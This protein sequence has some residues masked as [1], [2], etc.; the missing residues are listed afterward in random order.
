MEP[1]RPTASASVTTD[2]LIWR[3]EAP[4]A[5]SRASSRLRWA[6]RIEKVLMM[7]KTP[8]TSE[9]PANTS[10]NVCRKPRISSRVSWFFLTYS[11]PVRASTPAGS[12]FWAAS[13]SCC[14]ET[15]SA[16][17]REIEE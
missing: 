15:P 16:A 13:A 7:R 9:I 14:C 5:R 1:T 3:R 10:R 12:T 17:F 8:T 2:R 11:S 4:R 6:T